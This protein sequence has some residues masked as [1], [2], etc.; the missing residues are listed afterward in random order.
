MGQRPPDARSR[1]RRPRSSARPCSQPTSATTALEARPARQP[2]QHLPDDAAA[3]AMVEPSAM[4]R[5]RGLPSPCGAAA[6]TA[7]HAGSWPQRPSGGPENESGGGGKPPTAAVP[8]VA[9]IARQYRNLATEL[10]S[11]VAMRATSSMAAC[12]SVMAPVVELV[13]VGHRVDVLRDLAGRRAPPRRRCGS[14]PSSSRS[15]PRR[16]RRWCSASR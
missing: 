16:R 2:G 6:D 1:S 15:A 14:S 7:R 9:P 11:E 3:I 10:W 4:P 8:Q 13:A 12:A 5:S